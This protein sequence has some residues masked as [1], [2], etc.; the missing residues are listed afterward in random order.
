MENLAGFMVAA[1]ALTGSPGPAVLSVAATGAAFGVARGLLYMIGIDTG[2]LA[3]IGLVASGVTGLVLA[4][5]GAAP[6]VS[7]LAAA[8]FLY[9]AWRIATAPPLTDESAARP[10]P[11]F[12]A[13]VFLALVN[14]KAYAAMAAMF[15]GFTLVREAVALDIAVKTAVLMA[16]IVA[17]NIAWLAAGAALTRLFREKRSNR[18]VNVSFAILLLASLVLALRV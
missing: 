1:L 8:Y 3:V 11:S 6:V 16:I 10:P 15:S 12:A 17:V 4:I 14:P 2:M 9:L 5:P 13:G 7:L 18:I